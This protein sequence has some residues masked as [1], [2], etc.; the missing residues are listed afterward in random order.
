MKRVDWWKIPWS[1][2]CSIWLLTSAP[3]PLCFANETS[4]LMETPLDVLLLD[5]V[6]NIGTISIVF[7]YWNK[8][9]EGKIPWMC[10]Y[11]IWLLT[12]APFPLCF[13]IETSGL[14]ENPLD[15][16]LL[17]KVINIGTI[18][19]VFWRTHGSRVLQLDMF[20]K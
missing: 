15:V 20:W 19:I 6:T 8:W 1:C 17:D 16:M 7:C 12:S 18:S 3:F 13:A 11:S 10:C 5:M 9:T 14:M 2:C 4:G